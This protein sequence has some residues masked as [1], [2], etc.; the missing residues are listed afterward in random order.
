MQR[1][2]WQVHA[3]AVV[4]AVIELHRRSRLDIH[5]YNV[6]DWKTP[7]ARVED[8]EGNGVLLDFNRWEVK[9]V[10]LERDGKLNLKHLFNDNK[11]R[12][13]MWGYC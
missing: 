11:V 12:G 13:C 2:C 9:Q 4:A 8:Q 6:K 10:Q 5:G 1:A 3:A 7:I